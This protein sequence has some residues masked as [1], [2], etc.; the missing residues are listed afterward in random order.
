MT[1]SYHPGDRI[2]GR[3]EIAGRPLM[4]GMGIVLVCYDHQ[5]Q[6]P[7]ALKTFRPEFLPDRAARDRFLRECTIWV[8][9]G[10]HPHIIQ[11]YQVT[12]SYVSLEV[13]L[14]LELVSKEKGRADA[15]L[16]SWL[17][18]GR[19][20][21]V[22]TGLLFALQIARGMKHAVQT[23]PGFVHRDLKP[24]NVLVGA[25]RLSEAN[26]NRLR[27]TDFGLA[28]VLEEQRDKLEATGTGTEGD[29]GSLRRTQLTRGIVGTPLYMAP[30]QWTG[31]PPDVRTDVYAFGCILYEMLTG[32]YA[33]VG[34]TLHELELAHRGGRVQRLPRK[35]PT[36]V[37]ELVRQCLSVSRNSRYRSWGEAEAVLTNAYRCVAGKDPP[38]EMT[39]ESK[40]P[41]EQMAVGWS[42]NAIGISYMEIGN[43]NVAV[44]YFERAVQIGNADSER[45]LEAG[46]VN[47]GSAYGN[48]GDSQRAIECFERCLTISREIGHRAEEGAALGNL[49]MLIS[50]WAMLTEQSSCIS[51]I[52]QLHERLVIG[53]K[54]GLL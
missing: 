19:P 28:R 52:W 4:G 24:E 50:D 12:Q 46:L 31:E 3:Y 23:I 1:A 26:V 34:K 48:L 47:L 36:E 21:P 18:P 6:H 38:P 54:K 5:E 41:A 49:A 16:R 45:L 22:E 30:E 7:V 17:L 10:S 8:N 2:A 35:L 32:K 40:M 25:D 53:L 9:L 20:L 42:Y 11:C 51:R 15:S 27:V 44:E 39:S 43:F 37:T 14:V 29:R 13:Y 33:V